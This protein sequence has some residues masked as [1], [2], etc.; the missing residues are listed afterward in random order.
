MRDSV[1][2]FGLRTSMRVTAPCFSDSRKSAAVICGTVFRAPASR[3]PLVDHRG[4]EV[5]RATIEPDHGEIANR[6]VDG[7][8]GAIVHD[9][10]ENLR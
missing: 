7:L 1:H 3:T 6:R 2:S 8:R 5:A 4:V 10:I 9:Q